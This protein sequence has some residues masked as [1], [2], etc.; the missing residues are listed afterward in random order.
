MDCIRCE[1]NRIAIL[2][3]MIISAG[4]LIVLSMFFCKPTISGVGYDDQV[5]D[6]RAVYLYCESASEL[7]IRPFVAE[8]ENLYYFIPFSN[9][10][11]LWHVPEDAT[12]FIDGQTIKTA[13]ALTIQDSTE[14]HLFAVV[15]NNAITD[16]Y[17][18]TCVFANDIPVLSINLDQQDLDTILAEDDPCTKVTARMS[19][20]TPDGKINYDKSCVLGGHGNST[21]WWYDKRS[22]EVKVDNEVSLLG[23]RSS[24][25]WNI[26]A[27]AMDPSNLKNK[28]VYEAA[29]E[30][31][32][33]YYVDDSYINFYING[34]YYG[35]YLLTDKPGEGGAITF[36][37]D[38]EDENIKVNGSEMAMSVLENE[39]TK[40]EIRYYD[41]ESSPPDISGSYHME[42]DQFSWELAELVN[43][44][45]F[46]TDK[47]KDEESREYDVMIK[48]PQ[49][50]NKTEVLYLRDYIRNAEAAIYSENGVDSLT[51][52][53]Y[54]EYIDVNSWAMS[55][56]FM[57]FFAYQDYSAGSLFFYKKRDNDLLYSGPIWDYD[58]CMTDNPYDDDLFPWYGKNQLYLWYDQMNQFNDFHSEV[59]ENYKTNLSPAME[60][61]LDNK[62]SNW[63][64]LIASSEVM[65]EL[66]WGEKAGTELNRGDMVEEW[67]VRRKEL[68]DSVWVR[69]ESSPYADNI[70]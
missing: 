10:N 21:W 56:L 55:Y 6:Y 64:T 28:I 8:D 58:K 31:G 54:K 49:N 22:F 42:F 65:D 57:D 15:R 2:V 39:G 36:P 1:M 51:G 47:S 32:Y 60:D 25:K 35:L 67:L 26:I 11:W 40:E 23:I 50:A 27:N 20:F 45:W 61:I 30:C 44:P 4:L 46:R 43:D 5:D 48:Y 37:D 38:L 70:Y 33:E 41:L 52:R 17:Y 19:L 9:S 62:L 14:R 16:F 12:L 29:K 34:I 53:D 7:R 3:F 66:R 59:V 63:R 13:D 69:G 18:M 24:K 68:F